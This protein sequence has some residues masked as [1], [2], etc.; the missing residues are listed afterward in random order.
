M[1]LQTF[2]V[3]TLVT[4]IPTATSDVDIH[5]KRKNYRRAWRNEDTCTGLNKAHQ[6]TSLTRNAAMWIQVLMYGS[7]TA[8]MELLPEPVPSD[9]RT[10][11]QEWET[12]TL[13]PAH[14][15][16]LAM[17]HCD[18]KLSETKR[19]QTDC[20]RGVL[21]CSNIQTKNCSLRSNG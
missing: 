6:D 13:R 1:Q 16:C 12:A 19:E 20:V 3:I 11:P 7:S 18:N 4:E 8:A 5:F 2:K 10:K 14:Y 17:A 15:L 21:M 9:W